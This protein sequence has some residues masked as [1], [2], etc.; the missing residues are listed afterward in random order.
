[1]HGTAMSMQPPFLLFCVY[2]LH[3]ATRSSDPS[4]HL[5]ITQIEGDAPH[6]ISV[7]FTY[8]IKWK[9][10]DMKYEH[11]HE[12]SAQVSS[13]FG[14]LGRVHCELGFQC[15]TVPPPIGAFGMA[16]WGK[17]SPCLCNVGG[18]VYSCCCYGLVSLLDSW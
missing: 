12:L 8:S 10:T 7:T 6:D 1:M 16:P 5:D 15:L 2:H 17:C 18:D 13:V 11:R 4:Q 9:P 3:G 14:H